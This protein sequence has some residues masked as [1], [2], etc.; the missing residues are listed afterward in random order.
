MS[1]HTLLL[2]VSDTLGF[3]LPVIFVGCLFL[4]RNLAM[5]VT[6]SSVALWS[7]IRLATI[8]L[9]RELSPPLVG[10]VVAPFIAL[11]YLVIARGII[12]FVKRIFVRK[13]GSPP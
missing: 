5:W 6:F 9:Y 13:P 1:W 12:S 10:F 8:G 11:L 7:V 4:R 3:A 2:H